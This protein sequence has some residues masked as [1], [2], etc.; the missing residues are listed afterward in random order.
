M[1][2]I[3]ATTH[4]FPKNSDTFTVF[5]FFLLTITSSINI[6]SSGV[7]TIRSH[8]LKRSVDLH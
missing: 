1:I 2:S 3:I 6:D 7:R 4:K 8:F 5:E